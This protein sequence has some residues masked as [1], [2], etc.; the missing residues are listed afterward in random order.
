M[1][2]FGPS[3][4]QRRDA[5]FRVARLATLLWTT[6]SH[7]GE[8]PWETRQFRRASLRISNPTANVASP[9][10]R[11]INQ[12]ERSHSPEFARVTGHRQSASG[13]IFCA[14]ADSEGGLRSPL[15]LDNF[16]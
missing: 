10:L 4:R 16:Q 15:L 6:H 2:I 5:D 7:S 11:T 3:I 14:R 9:R 1:S 12:I 13:A 8:P